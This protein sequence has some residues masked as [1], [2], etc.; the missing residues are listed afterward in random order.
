MIDRIFYIDIGQLLC[1]LLFICTIQGSLVT[2]CVFGFIL[3]DCD[4]LQ[5]SG[6]PE[7]SYRCRSYVAVSPF[8]LFATA[9]P[10][11][12]RQANKIIVIFRPTTHTPYCAQP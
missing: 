2:S 4:Y 9:F 10:S 11:A 7:A 8:L 6:K 5:V 1:G 12:V 3:A